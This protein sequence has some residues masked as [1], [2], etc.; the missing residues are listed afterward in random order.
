MFTGFS[1]P[2]EAQ[3]ADKCARRVSHFDQ[4]SIQFAGL[5]SAFHKFLSA[6]LNMS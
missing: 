1:P 5:K 4:N 6:I 2:P 3:Q